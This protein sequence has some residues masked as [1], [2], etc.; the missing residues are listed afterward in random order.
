MAEHILSKRVYLAV[1][2]ALIALA[3]LTTAISY[4]D[5]GLFNSVAALLIA[6]LKTALVVL[7]FM[8]VRYASRLTWVFVIAGFCWLAILMALSASDYMTR[9]WL[10]APNAFPWH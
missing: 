6:G 8:H 5:L 10:P 3:L 9:G 4:I 7:W 1:F 2:G